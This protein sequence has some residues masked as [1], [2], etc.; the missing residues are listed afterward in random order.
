MHFAISVMTMMIRDD[1]C[2]MT[3]EYEYW[4]LFVWNGSIGWM[5]QIDNHSWSILPLKVVN[6]S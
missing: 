1:C 4:I 5:H 2:F 6:N 3:A